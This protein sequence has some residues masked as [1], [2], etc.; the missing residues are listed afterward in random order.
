VTNIREISTYDVFPEIN[1]KILCL[2][3]Y[4][5]MSLGYHPCV[6]L[7]NNYVRYTNL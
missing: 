1:F 7:V 4:S 2:D 3:Q 6:V 5:V